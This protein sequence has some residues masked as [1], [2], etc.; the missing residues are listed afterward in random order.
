VAS[1]QQEEVRKS[2][3]DKKRT[4]RMTAAKN[5]TETRNLRATGLTHGAG[6]AGDSASLKFLSGCPAVSAEH[7]PATSG[8]I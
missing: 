7:N 4:H 5:W 8:I 2:G 6:S 1:R 3:G